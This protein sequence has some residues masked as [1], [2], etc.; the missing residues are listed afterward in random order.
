MMHLEQLYYPRKRSHSYRNNELPPTPNPTD[1]YVKA[2]EEL[3]E[4]KE[5]RRK[6]REAMEEDEEDMMQSDDE[7]EEVV[8][9][10]EGGEEKESMSEEVS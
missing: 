5:E 9:E 7:E 1:E 10:V 6:E 3:E 2:L 8:E 4:Q